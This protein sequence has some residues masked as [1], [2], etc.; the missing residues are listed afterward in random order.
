MLPA[1]AAAA[2]VPV[3]VVPSSAAQ[4]CT[5]IV[6]IGSCLTQD[7]AKTVILDKVTD[8]NAVAN[9][10]KRSKLC[11][12]HREMTR[13]R[14]VLPHNGDEQLEHAAPVDLRKAVVSTQLQMRVHKRSK[15]LIST[16][17]KQPEQSRQQARSRSRCG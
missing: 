3:A 8:G 7:I 6:G 4:G 16:C 12:F 13:T 2:A 11:L 10:P 17:I 1:G 9:R 14:D 15:R 5:S